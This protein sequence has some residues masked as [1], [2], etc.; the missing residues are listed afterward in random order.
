KLNVDE[1]LLGNLGTSGGGGIIRIAFGI[2]VANFSQTFGYEA[3]MEAEALAPLI[4][5]IPIPWK[6][7]CLLRKMKH[8]LSVGSFRVSHV[9]RE[10]NVV[11]DKLA[12]MASSS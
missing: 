7:H 10:D 8:Y 11:V 6:L 5:H 1:S 12:K 4:G 2:P 3:D 9:H